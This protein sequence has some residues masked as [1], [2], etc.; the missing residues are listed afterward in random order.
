MKS[1]RLAALQEDT[2]QAIFNLLAT[3]DNPPFNS[4]VLLNSIQQLATSPLHKI[5]PDTLVGPIE[6]R[7]TQITKHLTTQ[8]HVAG[9]RAAVGM[10]G[11]IVT[12]T[13]VSWAGWVGWLTGSGG[14]GLL[15]FIGLDAGTALGVGL[16]I[17]IGSVRWAV[18][19]WE[20]S[21]RRWWDD[22]NRVG[23]GLERD[24]R[25]S[26]LICS[27]FCG[28][29]HILPKGTLDRTMQDKVTSTAVYGCDQLWEMADD[30][31]REIEEL[32]DQVDT[33]TRTLEDLAQELNSESVE[34]QKT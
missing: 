23:K 17:A 24:L 10:S 5:T 9:Q 33:L 7:Q 3:H 26:K 27:C 31:R 12:G 14:E 18:G 16:V 32:Q 11:G 20:R 34:E 28:L 13:T 15:G 25:V 19:K 30:R 1:G 22:W 2:T 8:L 6:R 29:V 21:K 4:N